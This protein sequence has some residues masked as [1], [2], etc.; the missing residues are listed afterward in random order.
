MDLAAKEDFQ[1][2][3]G[4]SG[5]GEGGAEDEDNAVHFRSEVAGVVGGQHGR[6]VEDDV[7]V[8]RVE[9]FDQSVGLFAEKEIVGGVGAATATEDAEVFDFG[10]E[11]DVLDFGVF[12][13]EI[14]EAR[15][16]G[17]IE[18]GVERSS[19]H[20]GVDEEGF[21]AGHGHGDGEVGG[22]GRFS[23][24]RNGAGDE[25][26]FG[27]RAS[28]GHEEDGGADVAKRFE[29]H[30]AV[31]VLGNEWLVCDGSARDMADDRVI[32]SGLHFAER[33]DAVVELIDEEKNANADDEAA[34]NA[35]DE[36]FEKSA[37]VGFR[38]ARL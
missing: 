9:F 31:V 26:R 29:Q 34:E 21:C 24:V 37:F 33:P 28:V 23:F 17:R 16:S 11:N 14:G 2:A 13:E 27:F 36:R 15:L 19:A 25:E 5:R 30:V 7:V 4:E 18:K 35:D 1:G 3:A 8:V 6:A 22:D 38:I 32:K 12:R 20:I 10:R